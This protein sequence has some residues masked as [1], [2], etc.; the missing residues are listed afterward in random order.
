MHFTST[1]LP[2]RQT[3]SFSKLAVDYIDQAEALRPFYFHAPNWQGIQAAIEER[4][5]YPINRELLAEQLEAQYKDVA[6]TDK[7]QQNIRLLLS[8]NTFTITTAHQPNLFTGPLY[9]I[10]KIL[11]AI[12]LAEQCKTNFP[13]FYFVPVYYMGSEDADLDELGHCYINGE[14]L[15]WDTKQTGAVGRMK[16]DKALLQLIE[17]ISG[18]VTVLPSGKEIIALVRDCYKEGM[19][20]QDAT[21][22]FVHALFAEYGLLVLIPDNAAL[23]KQAISIFKDDLLNQTASGILNNTIQQLDKAGYKVQVNPREINLFYLVDGIRSRIELAGDSYIVHDSSLR[24]TKE[25]LLNMLQTNPERF[26]P[27]VV[28]RGLFQEMILPDIVF[29]G[30]GGEL[31]YWMELK[32]LFAHYKVSYPV[33]LLRNSFLVVEKKWQ[34]RIQKLGITIDDLFLPEQELLNQLV[35]KESSNEVQLNGNFSAAEQLYETVKQQAGAIDTTLARHVEALKVQS[36]NR[37]KELEKKML[38]A[39][40]RKF[41][42]QQRQI[43]VLKEKLFPRDGLQERIDNFIPYYAGWGKDFIQQ[44]YQYSLTTEQ[45]FVVLRE[46]EE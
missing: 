37:L 10:Y 18:Q 41:S 42:E 24:F 44:L 16:I 43:H 31:A 45:E 13:G 26:S 4:K 29:I 20:I 36:L 7:V 22:H 33:L 21:F 12:K 5:K 38:R 9:F 19:M 2:Y 15:N 32:E 34:E 3:R 46:K 28:L 6:M 30:G 25:E 35:A 17:R 11:H 23:K 27:N 40:K 14:K 1:R 8:P 39:E